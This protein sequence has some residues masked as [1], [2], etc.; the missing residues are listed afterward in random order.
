MAAANERREAGDC[1]DFNGPPDVYDNSEFLAGSP[2]AEWL[3][4]RPSI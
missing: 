2:Q 4:F 3:C 1:S